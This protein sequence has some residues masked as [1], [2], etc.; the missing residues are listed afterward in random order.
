MITCNAEARKSLRGSPLSAPPNN[1]VYGRQL[2][3]RPYL[4]VGDSVKALNKAVAIRFQAVRL[5]SRPG[6]RL[7]L[8]SVQMRLPHVATMIEFHSA[9]LHLRSF[10]RSVVK[11]TIPWGQNERHRWQKKPEEVHHEEVHQQLSRRKGKELRIESCLLLFL[12]AS[13][14]M[15]KPYIASMDTSALTSPSGSSSPAP[16]SSSGAKPAPFLTAFKA[17]LFS[18]IYTT[19]PPYAKCH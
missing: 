15:A 2:N 17:S 6:P 4:D 5:D 16:I 1:R 3:R 8:A 14:S 7:S 12:N 9:S 13:P 11:H 19:T 10:E 18:V